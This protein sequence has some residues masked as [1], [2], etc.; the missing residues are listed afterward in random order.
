M[1]T[2][3]TKKGHIYCYKTMRKTAVVTSLSGHEGKG[4]VHQRGREWWPEMRG[5]MRPL[6][7]KSA[8][9]AAMDVRAGPGACVRSLAVSTLLCSRKLDQKLR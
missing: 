1:V 6:K 9:S 8:R 2:E 3:M 4:S 5:T 7:Q